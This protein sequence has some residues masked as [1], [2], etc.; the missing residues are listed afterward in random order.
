MNQ[1]SKSSIPLYSITGRFHSNHY[2]NL[3]VFFDLPLGDIFD[4]SIVGEQLIYH[5]S[6]KKSNVTLNLIRSYTEFS[7][8]LQVYLYN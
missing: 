7:G 3:S 5:M 2:K 4:D 6:D 8:D 1:T